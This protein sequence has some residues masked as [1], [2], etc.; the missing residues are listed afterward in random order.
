MVDLVLRPDEITVEWLNQAMAQAGVLDGTEIRAFEYELIGTGK[1]GDNARFTLQ[2][3]GERGSAPATVVGKFAAADDTARAMASAGGAYYN[4]VMFYREFAP[5]TT[6]STPRIYADAL[7]EDK[8]EFVLLME[9]MAPAQPGNNLEGASRQQAE[10]PLAE[11]ARLAAAFYGDTEFGARDHVMSA[12]RDDG[13]E[14]GGLLM[15]E[16]WP[17]FVARF[18]EYLSPECLAFGDLYVANHKKFV[19]LYEGPK[20]LVHGD[21]RSENVLF[22]ETRATIVDWQTP[23]ESS[24]LTDATYFIGGSLALEDRRAWEQ[25]LIAYYCEQLA[26]QGVSL[27]FDA[28]WEQYRQQAMHGII[29]TVPGA[30][31]SS[32]GE[33][34]DRMFTKMIQGHL[35]HYLDLDAGEF[36]K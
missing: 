6:M 2:Y 30:S 33:R 21:M 23:G 17:K 4:E 22:G 20:T 13:G 28:C 35:Q 27:S 26:E 11:A 25:E 9:D 16:N 29:I 7:S 12:A 24:P 36:L 15:Q 5:R 3:A 19:S 34:S 10:R 18:G 1:M 31:F 14:F 32:P 8:T